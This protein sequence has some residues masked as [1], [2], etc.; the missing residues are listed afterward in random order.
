MTQASQSVCVDWGGSN[1]SCDTM[2]QRHFKEKRGNTETGREF[3]VG[4]ENYQLSD[5]FFSSAQFVGCHADRG[6][7]VHVQA[8]KCLLCGLEE[9]LL[10]K[11]M[12]TQTVIETWT[13]MGSPVLATTWML[14]RGWDI[15]Q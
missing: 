4:C 9:I 14:S 1:P 12:P 10:S 15:P 11:F 13:W 6:F 2:W 7:S 5:F 3:S 8:A